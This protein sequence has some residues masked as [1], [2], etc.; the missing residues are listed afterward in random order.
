[1]LLWSASVVCL[2]DFSHLR[3]DLVLDQAEPIG[4]SGD[5]TFEDVQVFP[6][7]ALTIEDGALDFPG[8]ENNQLLVKG[9]A[10]LFQEG[11]SWTVVV[12]G[13][14]KNLTRSQIAISLAASNEQKDRIFELQIRPDRPDIFAATG[15]DGSG[16]LRGAAVALDPDGA[17][18]AAFSYNATDETMTILADEAVNV[19]DVKHL[20]YPL[21]D[22]ILRLGA[23]RTGSGSLEGEISM[24][25]IYDVALDEADLHQIAGG[26]GDIPR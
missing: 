16:F 20:A 22:E 24:L 25:R 8:D 1:M 23:F 13:K 7:G 9:I 3:F 19:I 21:P 14:T 18:F 17:F 15:G 10:E 6:P 4:A 12:R 26:S 5:N 11:E 2:A